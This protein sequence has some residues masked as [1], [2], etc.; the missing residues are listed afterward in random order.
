[1][2]GAKLVKNLNKN[3]SFQIV[4]YLFMENM[5][6]LSTTRKRSVLPELQKFKQLGCNGHCKCKVQTYFL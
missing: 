6:N 2:N 1:M 4:W 3:G 5:K